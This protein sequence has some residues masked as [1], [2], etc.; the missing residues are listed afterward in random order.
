MLRF[1][2]AR[3]ITIPQPHVTRAGLAKNLIRDS[4]LSAV[5][6]K[7]GASENGQIVEGQVACIQNEGAGGESA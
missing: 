5:V 7:S 3:E 1:L 4:H 2:S 6:K